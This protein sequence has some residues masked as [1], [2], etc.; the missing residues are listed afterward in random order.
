[1]TTAPNASRPDTA[2]PAT[3]ALRADALQV[4]RFEALVERARKQG[5]VPAQAGRME[6]VLAALERLVDGAS[7]D[8]GAEAP[9]AHRAPVQI[10]VH[11]CPDCAAATV[12]TATGERPL[13][14]AQVAALACD[15]QV[16]EPGR[17]N[18]ATIPPRVRRAVLARDRHRC[19]TPG[20]GATAF[21]EVH[22]VV[23][24]RRGGSNQAANLVTLCGRCHAFAHEEAP[25]EAALAPAQVRAKRRTR[26]G[27]RPHLRRRK[28]RR[29]QAR[30][31]TGGGTK[32]HYALN[33]S[34]CRSRF[35]EATR[36]ARQFVPGGGD[37][38][39]RAAARSAAKTPPIAQT[40]A[41]TAGPRL[42]DQDFA[43]PAN[44]DYGGAV[45]RRPSPGSSGG[46]PS[47]PFSRSP[48]WGT[49]SCV[50]SAQRSPRK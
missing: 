34:R 10:V 46:L 37:G 32:V 33:S 24:R 4:A 28:S 19:T 13:A 29:E 42:A 27:G 5:R 17:P 22:H 21:L 41:D 11:Q 31:S 18:R 39:S 43:R 16:L 44:P 23:P 50:R 47:W 6:L 1:M 40:A 30:R 36:P 20:C 45:K 7:D 3:V 14:P 25:R 26:V 12:T 49:R 9:R 48:A 15:A 8:G 38:I 35:T 2:I